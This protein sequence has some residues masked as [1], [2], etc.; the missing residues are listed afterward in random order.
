MN[1]LIYDQNCN[2]TIVKQNGLRIQY[3]NVDKPG[4]DF[5]FDVLVYDKEEFK[6]VDFSEEKGNENKRISLTDD[7]RDQIETYIANAEAPEGVTL[8]GQF[9]DDLHNEVAQNIQNLANSLRFENLYEANYAGREGSNH[10]YRSDARRVLEF[11]DSQYYQLDKTTSEI[12]ATREDMLKDY[13]YYRGMVIET[14][15]PYIMTNTDNL[16]SNE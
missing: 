14:Q 13:V 5:D 11:A 9:C 12:L 16:E 8:N 2:L 1:A 6:I 3:D 10:P 15:N 7:E 4:F